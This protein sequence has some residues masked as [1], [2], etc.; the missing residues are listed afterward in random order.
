MRPVLR[1]GLLAVTVLA[2]FFVVTGCSSSS[3]HA[4]AEDA[5]KGSEVIFFPVPPD[6]PR[7]QYL[8]Y[9]TGADQV[10]P[11]EQDEFASFILGE[12]TGARPRLRKPFGLA[13]HDGIIYACDTTLN[14]VGKF[15]LKNKRFSVFG[16]SGSGNLGKP[17]NLVVDRL[18][19][20]FVADARRNEVVVFDPS[21]N[22]VRAFKVPGD[23]IR[24]VDVALHGD[25]LYVLNNLGAEVTVLSRTTGA[26]L[27]KFGKR[28]AEDGDFSMPSGI[29]A[30]PDGSIYVCDPLDQ[31]IQKLS[32]DGKPIWSKGGPGFVLGTFGRPRGIEVDKNG[33]LYI[34][35]AATCIVQMW[36]SD[37][38]VLMHFAG[39]GDTPGCLSLPSSVAVDSSGTSYL[40][41]RAHPDFK[42]HTLIHVASQ[43]G[44]RLVSTYMLGEF[45]A[46]Y[47]FGGQE[48]KTIAPIPATEEELGALPSEDDR[49]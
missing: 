40:G 27:R 9:F 24:V 44:P 28:G 45:P 11:R 49:N 46:G 2:L 5:T 35:D 22:F 25:E 48:F 32:S 3:G 7:V 10:D 47:D 6:P 12:D 17:V 37:G 30:G 39:S 31:R 1:A 13:A 34:V 18:G 29:A 43:F 33:I 20:K 38:E 14:C 8:T 15:D 26:V 41:D 19:F 21:D 36:N 16:N 42:G 4:A 23:P